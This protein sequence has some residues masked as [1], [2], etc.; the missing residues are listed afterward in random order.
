MLFRGVLA[1]H[2]SLVTLLASA[3]LCAGCAGA[4][5]PPTPAAQPPATLTPTEDDQALQ[6]SVEAAARA[7]LVAQ[8]VA[9]TMAV[10]T[11]TRL[12]TST[13]HR[14]VFA[15]LEPFRHGPAGLAGLMPAGW[16]LAGDEHSL[17]IRSAP[18][19]QVSLTAT[20]TPTAQLPPDGP[21]GATNA[22]F[23]QVKQSGQQAVEDTRLPGGGGRLTLTDGSGHTTTYVRTTVT[24]RGLLAVTMTAPTD[25]MRH[26]D[27]SGLEFFDSIKLSGDY[28]TSVPCQKPLEAREVTESEERS[29]PK[30]NLGSLF[31]KVNVYGAMLW[32]TSGAVGDFNGDGRDDLAAATDSNDGGSQLYIV[33]QQ[34]RGALG[35]PVCFTL[36]GARGALAVGDLN[37]DGHDDVVVGGEAEQ[38][39]V[40]LS[41][42]EG[43]FGSRRDLPAGDLPDA[44]AVGDLNGDGRDDVVA[45]H[46]RSDFVGLWLQEAGGELAPML[47]LPVDNGGNNSIAIGDL[48][49]DGSL[50]IVKQPGQ[51][52]NLLEIALQQPDHSFANMVSYA[53]E[54]NPNGLAIGDVTGDGRDDIVTASRSLVGSASLVVVYELS[55]GGQLK[56]LARY[57]ISAGPSAV[58][59][60][61]IDGDGRN[62]VAVAHSDSSAFS[63]LRQQPGGAM[64]SEEVYF[65]LG[66][67]SNQHSLGIGD[68]NGDGRQDIV[69]FGAGLSLLYG[70]AP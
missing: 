16:S 15:K 45:S 36:E 47:S 44:L 14:L 42:P 70:R 65:V 19:L 30:E 60:A 26:E 25:L 54:H 24:E 13:P 53:V 66:A 68:L 52:E 9:A 20:L 63:L 23:A 1:H 41:A 67:S 38:I 64:G 62:D 34:P 27:S 12:P 58:R 48:N 37:S 35:A 17:T 11:A 29:A 51:G 55:A 2:R 46:W 32:L 57:P 40:F 18:E 59:I 33:L 61:D 3:L 8:A 56:E 39:E 7:T 28:L 69:V 21:A 50:D 10:P 49:S 22:L 43:I 4:A 5:Q 31:A 6:A